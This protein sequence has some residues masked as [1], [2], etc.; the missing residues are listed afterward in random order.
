MTENH[1]DITIANGTLENVSGCAIL[2]K[3]GCQNIAIN[4]IKTDN[5]GIRGNINA[6]PGVAGPPPTA[7]N[8]DRYG[9]GAGIIVQGTL[10][11]PCFNLT[12]THCNIAST[13]GNINS[14]KAGLN[15]AGIFLAVAHRTLVKDCIISDVVGTN[16]AYG[17]V[18]LGSNDFNLFYSTIKG[19]RCT[20]NLKGLIQR[21]VKNSAVE[22][23]TF[24]DFAV[25]GPLA[26]ELE[27][28]EN[29]GVEGVV[30]RNCIVSDFS[31]TT[32]QVSNST[33][34]PPLPPALN[35][36]PHV[37]CIGFL[38]DFG[39]NDVRIENNIITNLTTVS[40]AVSPSDDIFQAAGIFVFIP[41]V[42]GV[43]PALPLGNVSI[44]NN[45]I[46]GISSN[47]GFAEGIVTTGGYLFNNP[48]FSNIR[49]CSGFVVQDN[50]IEF[51]TVQS[52][53]SQADGILLSGIEKGVIERN[54]ITN[55]TGHGILIHGL[56]VHNMIR[57]NNIE[58]CAA[59]GIISDSTVFTPSSNAI[60]SNRCHNNGTTNFGGPTLPAG[61][62]IR[63]WTLP[64]FPATIDNNSILDPNDNMDIR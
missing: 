64:G 8:P 9:C 57:D 12:I 38:V 4:K 63:V 16:F 35:T 19:L 42:T 48:A 37:F 45:F 26:D 33:F 2:V 22:N 21:A 15:A 51:I 53:A 24:A 62:P 6:D 23:C 61:T 58:S 41:S 60:L 31:I 18:N 52:E 3:D 44:K 50:G 14:S 40:T 30:F 7:A 32:Q 59:G 54:S 49:I 20:F 10:T 56:S 28:S 1:E 25:N 29:F 34:V 39:S 46:S 5:C 43:P 27:A 17:V 55:T 11:N 47:K 13:R 36:V